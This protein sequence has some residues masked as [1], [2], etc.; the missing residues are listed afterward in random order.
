MKTDRLYA[1][2]LYLLNHG[3]T[4]AAEL[5]KHFEVSVRTIQRDMD[6]LCQAGIPVYATTGSSGGYEITDTFQM[7]NQLM[8]KEDFAYIATALQ[9]LKTVTKDRQAAAILE[10]IST[11]ST[12]NDTGMILD[13]SVLREGDERLLQKLQSAV[14]NKQ[15]L[16]IVYTNNGGE[17]KTHHLEPIA[18]IY[19]WYAWYLLAYSREKKDYRT[20]KLVRMNEVQVT[21]ED[22]EKEHK[23]AESI[24]SD[25]DNSLKTNMSTTRVL[26]HCTKGAV[27]RIKE[28][29]H[30]KVIEALEDGSFLVELYVVESEHWWI[31]TLLSLGVGVMVLEPEHIRK[32]IVDSAKELLFLYEEL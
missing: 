25:S 11:L 18:V 1:I 27:H 14:L 17:T 32:R 30:G 19:R 6:S 13:F 21:G 9:G 16:R 12:Q 26:L 20:Y 23:S 8:S 5:A 24:L 28:Y 15:T 2:T 31:G 22:F 3:K 29:L 10:K 4:S 7:N